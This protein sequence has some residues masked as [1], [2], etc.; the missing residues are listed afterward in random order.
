[1]PELPE[2]ELVRRG[3]AAALIG[4]RLTTVEARRP[5]LRWPL[6]ADF[7]ARLTGRQVR[8]VRRRAKYLLMDF[9]DGLIMLGHLGM[10]GRLRVQ[11]PGQPQPPPGRH[12]H[13]MFHADDGT[14]VV[15]NDARRFGMLDLIAPGGLEGH[16]LLQ[17]L[18][19]EPLGNDFS[20]PV[21]A[22]A[23]AGRRLPLKAALLDQKL[24]AGLG[25][26]YVSE[27]LFRAGL[28]P[29]RQA[30]TVAGADAERLT[31]A[32]Q[33]VL[34]DAIAAGGSSLRSYVQTNGELGYFQKQF[35]VY[36][37]AGEACPTCG[38]T[39]V[40][41]RIVQSG[42]STYFCPEC[43]RGA[44]PAGRRATCRPFA[45]WPPGCCSACCWWRRPPPG[46]MRP[47]SCRASTICH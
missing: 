15:F 13:V 7:A 38:P 27:A 8:A 34:R 19:P 42:R 2:V 16:P 40:I 24:V 6:P 18:G 44:R 37:H 3:L 11:P 21:L 45:D 39:S 47:A 30:A 25:N 35:Q 22:A 29:Q 26:I 36:G 10:S 17:G 28:A 4:R 43:Q 12:D 20:G 41:Q 33:A 9:D 5:D 23:F 1:M 14:R 32:I 31:R 46:P